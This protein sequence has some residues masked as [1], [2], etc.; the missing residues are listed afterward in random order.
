MS[1]LSS[2]CFRVKCENKLSSLYTSSCAVLQYSVLCSLLFI[3]Y[4]TPLSTLIS[5]VSL[6][7]HIYADHTQLFFSFHPPNFDSSITHLLNALHHISSW[8]TA[9]LL[10]LNSS[11]TEFLLSGLKKQLAKIH[12]SSLNTTHSAINLGFTFDEHIT[13]SDQV[14]SLSKS[15]YYHTRQ[16]RCVCPHRDS[17]TA[18]TTASIV[19]SK[20]DHCKSQ[21]TCLQQIQKFLTCAIVNAPISCNTTAILSSL[22]WL[23]ITECIKYRLLSLT[24]IFLYITTQPSYLHNLIATGLNFLVPAYPFCDGK[25]AIERVSAVCHRIIQQLAATSVS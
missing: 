11:T 12:N 4:T 18:S 14:S 21:I 17:K 23:K 9:N 7:H 15:C 6:N 19:H 22:H 16:L 13:F 20:L 8:M 3:M 1:Y 5:S 25:E 10:T 24:C 2:E